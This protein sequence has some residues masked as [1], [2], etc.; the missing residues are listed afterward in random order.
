MQHYSL[1]E[2]RIPQQNGK[3]LFRSIA[4]YIFKITFVKWGK[5]YRPYYV[6]SC[7]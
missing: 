1:N 4:I 2:N 3:L 5:K 7:S 6:N